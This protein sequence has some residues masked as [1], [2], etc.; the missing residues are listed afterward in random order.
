MEIT[1][2]LSLMGFWI[3]GEKITQLP[4]DANTILHRDVDQW[5]EQLTL[6]GAVVNGV[7]IEYC[8]CSEVKITVL[9]C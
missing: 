9:M 8:W 3:L 2:A 4:A 6:T 5:C 1:T 7:N